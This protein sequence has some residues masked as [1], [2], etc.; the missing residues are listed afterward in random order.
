MLKNRNGV[1]TEE[2]G[3][4]EFPVLVDGTVRDELCPEAQDVTVHAISK[5]AKEQVRN[6]I[7]SV[8]EV[9]TPKRCLLLSFGT[10]INCVIAAP[11]MKMA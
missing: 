6:Q 7:Q 4:D 11:R 9:F 10:Y 2:E 8:R 5:Q 1:I 3:D